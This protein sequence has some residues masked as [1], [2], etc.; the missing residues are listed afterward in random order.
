METGQEPQKTAIKPSLLE[1]KLKVLTDQGIP[2]QDAIDQIATQESEA[3]RTAVVDELTAK[4]PRILKPT[5]PGCGADPL[6]VKR[7]R[8]E[9]GDHVIVEILFCHIPEC[10]IALAGQIVGMEQPKRR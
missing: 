10:R 7:L 4:E 8:Y 1:Q 6:V 5:C 9:F 2:R 3:R